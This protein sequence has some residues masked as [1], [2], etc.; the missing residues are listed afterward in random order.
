MSGKYAIAVTVCATAMVAV[1][2]VRTHP[3]GGAEAVENR[4][5]SLGLQ[6]AIRTSGAS[7]YDLGEVSLWVNNYTP[8]GWT[9]AAGQVLNIADY[10]DL[11]DRLGTTWGGDGQTTFALPDLRGRVPIGAGAGPGLTPRTLGQYV[12][13]SRVHLDADNLPVHAHETTDPWGPTT[14]VGGGQ[15]YTNLQDS[16]V[17]NFGMVAQRSDFDWAQPGVI[18]MYAT[19]EL[20]PDLVELDG[21]SLPVGTEWLTLWASLGFKYGGDYD[22]GFQVPDLRGRTPVGLGGGWGLGE[23]DGTE[24]V[25]LSDDALPAH[26]HGM[27]AGG[28]STGSA[29]A[30]SPEAID[31]DQPGLGLNFV[32]AGTGLYSPAGASSY[33]PG[34]QVI[35]QVALHAGRLDWMPEGWYVLNGERLTHYDGP[36]ALDHAM[37]NAFGG[38]RDVTI[39]TSD[40]WV[41]TTR[42][43]LPDLRGRLAIGALTPGSQGQV[44][45]VGQYTLD[46]AQLPAHSHEYVPEPAASTL[47]MTGIWLILRRRRA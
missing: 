28:S 23:M 40:G 8:P 20:P 17:L 46:E 16:A 35:G 41:D 37:G 15:A 1:G 13:H 42:F 10:P 33:P 4:Q 5:P 14:P 47:M 43:D 36:G 12:G 31:N 44:V 29:G 21:R 30:Q 3:A 26:T 38:R 2:Q 45:G 34:Y 11:Y 25:L 32:V 27:R 19:P 18:R 39:L 9:F 24:E 7:G 6:Y 22:S